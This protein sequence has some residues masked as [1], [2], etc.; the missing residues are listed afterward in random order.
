MTR[1]KTNLP[2]LSQL[3]SFPEKK[4]TANTVTAG[5]KKLRLERVKSWLRKTVT[6]ALLSVTFTNIP[7]DSLRANNVVITN[8]RERQGHATGGQYGPSGNAGSWAQ[9]GNW[10]GASTTNNVIVHLNNANSG[11][12]GGEVRVTKPDNDRNGPFQYWVGGSSSPNISGTQYLDTYGPSYSEQD[13]IYNNSAAYGTVNI[14]GSNVVSLV[15]NFDPAAQTPTSVGYR[16]TPFSI[17]NMSKTGTGTLQLG[18]QGLV[19]TNFTGYQNGGV[20]GLGNFG[21]AA[22]ANGTLQTTTVTLNG[23]TGPAGTSGNNFEDARSTFTFKSAGV[24]NTWNIGTLIANGFNSSGV[25]NVQ[26]STTL[27]YVTNIEDPTGQ[28]HINGNLR[29]NGDNAHN[30]ILNVLNQS[31]IDVT[32]TFYAGKSA[33]GL[34]SNTYINV[35]NSKIA[36][37]SSTILGQQNN[38]TVSAVMKGGSNWT[39]TGTFVVA[40]NSTNTKLSV[41]SASNLI[42]TGFISVGQN[43][44]SNG[45]LNVSGGSTVQSTGGNIYVA[46]NAGAT[47]MVNA[48]GTGTNV[49]TNENIFIANTDNTTGTFNADNGATVTAT[50]GSIFVANGNKVTGNVTGAFNADN[51]TVT[52]AQNIVIASGNESNGTFT[53]DNG[54]TINATAG[55]I[56]VA[57]AADST[58]N[59]LVKNRSSMTAGTYLE[60]AMASNS[61]GTI[62]ADGGGTNATITATNGH[63]ILGGSGKGT[64]DVVAKGKIF[65]KD[66]G[67]GTSDAGN[68][69]FGNLVDGYGKG[70]VADADS[71]L[72]VDHNL[73]VGNAGTGLLYIDNKGKVTVGGQHVIANHPT[74]FGRDIVNG[75]GTTLDITSNLIVGNEGRAGGYYNYIG[76]GFEGGYKNDPTSKGS[77]GRLNWYGSDHLNLTPADTNWNTIENNSPGLAIVAGGVTNVTVHVFA[78]QNQNG[79]AYILV[80]NI[81]NNFGS[82]N[83]KLNV[84]GDFIVADAGEAYLRVINGGITDV[85]GNM[86]IG[87]QGQDANYANNGKVGHGT[88]RVSG[89]SN[90]NATLNVGGDLIA[91][92]HAGSQGF[93]YVHENG[94][95]N[96]TGNHIIGNETGSFGRDHLDGSGSELKVTGDLHVGKDGKAG[97]QYEYRIDGSNADPNVW[98]DSPNLILEP[99]TQLGVTRPSGI[100]GS[101]DVT[102]NLTNL[103]WNDIEKNAPGLALTAGSQGTAKN[104]FAGTHAGSFSYVLID[105]KTNVNNT[106]SSLK[107]ENNMTIA[108]Y[109]VAYTR[110]LNGGSL[111]V[112]TNVTDTLTI[113]KSAGSQGTL[114]IG[115]TTG[116]NI[117]SNVS[118]IGTLIT[119]GNGTS[120]NIAEGYLYAGDGSTTQVTGTHTV[121]Q[122]Q[123]SFGREHFYGNGTTLRVTSGQATDK[124]MIAENGQ[125]GGH[126][127]YILGGGNAND[128]TVRKTEF[129]NNGNGKWFDSAN[130]LMEPAQ[131]NAG[132]NV[133]YSALTWDDVKNNSPGFALTA[134]ANAVTND[135]I[136]ANGS[137]SYGYVLLDNADN[138]SPSS[139]NRT[140]WIVTGANDANLVLGNT[141]DAYARVINGSL[142]QVKDNL[143]VANAGTSEAT[144]RI[145]NIDNANNKATLIV[146]NN[147]TVANETD[148]EGNLYAYNAAQVTVGD[149]NTHTGNFTIAND[150]NSY[151]RAHFDGDQTTGTVGGVLTVGQS[152][153][154]GLS[155]IYTPH[156]QDSAGNF[157]NKIN[158]PTNWFDS[159]NTLDD[160]I[161]NISQVAVG[162]NGYTINEGNHSRTF[163]AASNNPV[164]AQNNAPGF[165]VSDGAKVT[166]GQGMVGQE[167]GSSG[168]AVIDNKGTHTGRSIWTI[169][170]GTLTIAEH[171]NAYVRV[172]N[173][174][175]L[176]TT[177]ASGNVIIGNKN[178]SH[179]TLRVQDEGSQLTVKKDLITGKNGITGGQNNVAIGNFYLHNKAITD[180]EGIHT[181][182]EGIYSEG[183]DHIDGDDTKLTINGTL[184]VG[185]KGYAG[186]YVYHANDSDNSKDPTNNATEFNQWF[187][188]ANTLKDFHDPTNILILKE[189][190]PGLAITAGAKVISGNGIIAKEAVTNTPT[191]PAEATDNLFRSNG[192][193]VIDNTGTTAGR[194]E[195][196]ITSGLGIP[197]STGDL[198][199]AQ[200]GSG[201]G[202]VINGALLD[203]ANDMTIAE[204]S[205]G[206][207]TG[208]ARSDGTVRIYGKGYDND[209][210]LNVGRNLTTGKEGT[211]SLYIYHGAKGNV[212]DDHTVADV[213]GSYGHDHID[214]HDTKLTVGGMLTVGNSGQAGGRY[215]YIG[216][217]KSGGINRDPAKWFDSDNTMFTQADT[218]WDTVKN[219]APGLAITAGAEV[220]SGR[221]VVGQNRNI[222]DGTQSYGYVVIDSKDKSAT[223][224]RSKW[225]V[226]TNNLSNDHSENNTLIVAKNGESYVRVINGSLLEVGTENGSGGDGKMLIGSESYGYGTVRVNNI[227]PI[228]GT[229]PE[230]IVHGNLTTGG[231]GTNIDDYATGNLY[232]HDQ[233]RIQVDNNHVIAEGQYSVGRDHI[234][235]VGTTMNVE[236]TL[237][238]GKNGAAGGWYQ[239]NRYNIP[240]NQNILDVQHYYVPDPTALHEPERWLDHEMRT[241][242]NL[243]RTLQNLGSPENA[244]T[245]NVTGNSPGLAIT[246]GAVVT[247]GNGMVAETGTANGYVLIDDKRVGADSKDDSVRTRWV[248]QNDG[249]PFGTEGQLVVGGRGNAFV[250][251]LNGSLLQADSTVIA[252]SSNDN[253]HGYL[254]VIGG[255]ESPKD[256]DGQPIART[257]A[258]T[259]KPTTWLPSEWFNKGATVIGQETGNKRGTLRLEEGAHGVTCGLYIGLG[260][261]SQGEVSVSGTS[262]SPHDHVNATRSLLEVYEDISPLKGS[263]PQGSSTLSVSDYGYLWMHQHSEL[264]LNGVGIISNG[265]ILHLSEDK[266]KLPYNSETN[267]TN[268]SIN[269][270]TDPAGIFT[271]T[272]I[273]Q[274]QR[275]ALVDAMKSKITIVNARVEGDGTVT[276]EDG[277][278]IAHDQEHD[279][280]NTQTT[281]DP[282]QRYDWNNR[283]EYF[284][285]YGT[286]K[287]GDQLRMRGNVV[288]NFDVNSGYYAGMGGAGSDVTPQ[289]PNHDAIVVQRGDSS[290]SKADVLA[291]LSG[292]L[293]VHARLTD[294][295]QQQNDLLVV[296]TIGN[297]NPG[298]ILS[299]YDKLKVMPHRFFDDPRQEIRQ[300]DSNNDQLWITLKRKNN[301]FEE[302]GNTHNEKETG[303]GLD[304]IYMD[305]VK[306]GRK[307]W[308][309]VLRYFWYLDDP[310]FLNAYRLFSGEVRAHSLLLPMTNQWRYA[311]NRIDFRECNNVK[312]THNKP[313]DET[314]GV[315]QEYIRCGAVKNQWKERLHKLTKNARLWGSIVYDNTEINNDGN[316]ADS[317]LY[318]SGIVVGADRPF[319]KPESYLGVML[320][321][322][323]GK[324]NTFQAK[325]QDDD[326][327]AGLYHGTKL[328]ETWEWKNYLG[329]GVQDYSMI[330]NVNVNLTD[331]EWRQDD[332]Y[333][334]NNPLG[335]FGGSLTSDF[336][337]YTFSGSTELARPFYFG[338]CGE[339]QFRPYMALDMAMV[340]QNSDLEIGNFIN[341][342]LI[343]LEYL[344]AT[345]IRMYGRPG[346]LLERNKGRT[347]LH[348]GL[349]YAFLMGGRPYT[350]ADNRFQIGGKTFNIRGVDDGAGFVT[351]NFGGNVYLGKQKN[352][353]FIFDYWGSAGSHFIT[354]SAQF[355]LQKKF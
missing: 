196:N 147:L 54:S 152:G 75:H 5:S 76:V 205:D 270:I 192:Y 25:M 107:T 350:D 1:K 273:P 64:M 88:V 116:G 136:V 298:K 130:L 256:A 141:G 142:L 121:A 335:N 2:F 150:V 221:G 81:D 38:D 213:N 201:Y 340:W 204:L 285:Y 259:G 237:T 143:V 135:S 117:K 134:G 165:L 283:D 218:G 48:N 254:Y 318:R 220:V 287:F 101:L 173:G 330:R 155:Y 176:N 61:T 42:S 163:I 198:I 343:A 303:E 27:N 336:L 294:Y 203:V 83:S 190:M 89:S 154:A 215:D 98:F 23:N 63:F 127:R 43:N 181:I 170:N 297:T 74:S 18:I 13:H 327:S 97:G 52:S 349:S 6:T 62:T 93:L 30:T 248:V 161:S 56:T 346:F 86:V 118:V 102:N 214:G 355:G 99:G 158:D 32:G 234:D 50:T 44:A 105:D 263:K 279:V 65:V 354:Q 276:G 322:N 172:L 39:N 35:N 139:T 33:A 58:G 278:F 321:I 120:S 292:T 68:G 313:C 258:L 293:N 10:F 277:V 211:G 15:T 126:Y 262:A 184:T 339:Y 315:P 209:S 189:N 317:R 236:R 119:A 307:D 324:L 51:A 225:I 232:A 9:T 290:T 114:R 104:I 129:S 20:L 271:N 36:S 338:R 171:G 103:R 235:G 80:D 251:V 332:Y 291:Q 100:D 353:S 299:M 295:Y 241:L 250:R 296:Q 207:G 242:E 109:G 185:E 21:G 137:S 69:Y 94:K 49:I 183:R 326:F 146:G 264:R 269:F 312:H 8:G 166:S 34:A 304:S 316:A 179:G 187:D 206:V 188:S 4:I 22:L 112:G 253:K 159:V 323:R 17:S 314:L 55:Y 70:T 82:G 231:N 128:P 217:E 3:L 140:S 111:L 59:L 16:N 320:G 151:G 265:A 228:N 245:G 223:T 194:S 274:N 302:S 267:S 344:S 229:Q 67:T 284:S 14:T 325:A 286:L 197:A 210:T 328:F 108:D 288:T 95:V 174:A 40:Q 78:G 180:I 348:A 31:S 281:V 113:G 208:R 266:V 268:T 41:E 28:L 233:A 199:V 289:D 96:V 148:S 149:L 47:G 261:D 331:L 85:K 342:G 167:I 337:G 219:N 249:T 72:E 182:A 308:L 132:N 90:G 319:L 45:T 175:M 306:S 247:S 226:R 255:K 333:F 144:I 282:G 309:P 131:T 351:W 345:N 186:H 310:D 230:L 91:G 92:N 244:K 162:K 60:V 216:N 191:V 87:N 195:W 246:A 115:D 178:E 239:E 238:V 305:Q 352:C 222:N 73:I 160:D 11:G 138:D 110:V 334:A 272:P 227:D 79:Y 133:N 37:N 168:Y 202:R 301:P 212:T 122:G 57:S 125:A 77:L 24:S 26:N 280:T 341:S 156:L 53:A 145:N 7:I 275:T 300:D 66:A 157:D 29:V 177:S 200:E 106:H 12:N 193:F 169:D 153:R 252:Q 347:S 329:I 164:V 123:Y 124:T 19:I 71:L 257:D 260:T 84:T 46:Q 224:D 311:H 240:A 243:D